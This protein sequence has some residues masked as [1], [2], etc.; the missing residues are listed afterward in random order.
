MAEYVREGQ[1]AATSLPVRSEPIG[2]PIG[3]EGVTG[4]GIVTVAVFDLGGVLYDF[5]GGEV[6]KE[7]TT[8]P[9]R[10]AELLSRWASLPF[11]HAFETGA[12]TSREFAD[13]V[14]AAFQLDMT[15]HEFARRFR[16]AAR[17][18]YPRALDLVRQSSFA[19]KVTLSNTNELQWP[20]VLEAL[21]GDDPFDAHFP[22][23]FTGHHKPAQDAYRVVMHRFPGHDFV[24]F[25]DVQANVNAAIGAGMTAYRVQGVDELNAALAHAGALVDGG[26]RT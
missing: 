21:A 20:R 8:L 12:C 5:A 14:V 24:F 17:S 16:L 23:H 3:A 4:G 7:S 26:S 10:G 2:E 6:I 13:A 9:D 1:R 19:Y 18:F 25:D 15:A 11:V 22:S